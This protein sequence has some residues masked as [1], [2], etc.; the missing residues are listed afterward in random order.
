MDIARPSNAKQKRIKQ[1]I[2]VVVGLLV[3]VFLRHREAYFWEPLDS[4]RSAC[5]A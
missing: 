3:W 5:R 2:Y 1:T 4:S